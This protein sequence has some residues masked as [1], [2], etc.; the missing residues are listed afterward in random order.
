MAHYRQQLVPTRNAALIETV[1]GQ[2]VSYGGTILG[3]GSFRR[4]SAPYALVAEDDSYG[5]VISGDTITIAG[6]GLT[7]GDSGPVQANSRRYAVPLSSIGIVLSGASPR[8]ACIRLLCDS[9]TDNSE[10][11]AGTVAALAWLGVGSTTALDITGIQ[12][13]ATG[14]GTYQEV[15][16]RTSASTLTGGTAS[17]LNF[18]ST[19]LHEFPGDDGTLFYG[20]L[21]QTGAVRASGAQS[22]GGISA[23]PPTHLVLAFRASPG[24]SGIV[25]NDLRVTCTFGP[26]I[27]DI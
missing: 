14:S 3:D 10:A 22:G 21:T 12:R 19:L 4:L 8:Q 23:S 26:A 16:A 20:A 18:G 5:E 1:A 9:I 6:S 13:P 24:A 25:F 2:I 7:T 27:A 11:R 15:R 17:N